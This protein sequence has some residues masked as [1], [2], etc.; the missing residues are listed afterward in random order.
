MAA[1]EMILANL[2]ASRAEQ[3]PDLDVLTFEGAGVRSDEI[4]TYADLWQNGNRIAGGLIERGMQIGDRFALF[5]RNHPEFVDTMV[6]AS[7]SGTVFVPIDPRTKGAKLAYTLN[8]SQCRGIITADYA[9]DQILD[10]RDQLEYLDWIW[11]L[12]T[13]EGDDVNAADVE[14]AESL[15]AILSAPYSAV[16]IR[17]KTGSEPFEIIYT[18]GTTGDPKGVVRSNEAYGG[19]TMMGA[20][21]G[22]DESDRLYT[23]L[24]LTHGNAQMMTLGPT[25]G[26]GLRSVFSRKF[27]KSRL[28]DIT[29]KYGNTAFNLLG[30]MAMAIYS[31]PERD[32]D[33]DNPVRFVISAGMPIGI[34][35]R[36][37]KRFNIDILEAYGAIEGG[38]AIKPIGVGPVGSFG[39]QLPN[40]EMRIVDDDDNECPPG[41]L[42]EL[43]SRPLQG[44]QPPVEYFGNREASNKKTAG[45]W[46][47]SGDVCHTDEQG[48]FYFDYRKGG[49]IRHNGD[50]INPGFVEGVI[51]NCES[52]TDVFVYG[53]PAKS[54]S[55]GEKDVVAA[56]V[57][58]DP[59]TFEP[60]DVFSICRKELEA[61]FVPSYLQVVTE[62]PK[63]ASEK[64]QERFL[65]DQFDETSPNIHTE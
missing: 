49:G 16:D 3:K 29:R 27:T 36:F 2:I 28:W 62:I 65:L 30:G 17:V 39:K 1:N 24:S 4:R 35:E 47:R 33:A 63:T 13:D 7:V 42:G 53:V 6:G 11:V 32:N 37:E 64:P 23:G 59:Q 44:D 40:S 50:F 57:A 45:G 5:M 61:N 21:F 41:V 19:A 54:G 8:N 52:V 51:G 10:I 18:S 12:A 34:W 60:T 22:L 56:I 15:Q 25:L 58:T 31:E 20:I 46:L 26:M 48:W 9:I 43:V 55:P 38:M 14:G